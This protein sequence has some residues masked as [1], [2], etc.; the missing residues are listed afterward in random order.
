[1]ASFLSP[2][3]IESVKVFPKEDGIN[4]YELYPGTESRGIELLKKM[5]KFNPAERITAEEALKDS[6]FDDIRLPEQESS[7]DTAPV[8]LEFDS[9]VNA[10]LSIEEL[11]KLVV[12]EIEQISHENFDFANDFAEELCDDY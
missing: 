10:E 3:Q 7:A 1:M 9:E 5:L 2:K 8:N 4:L 6:Y 11:K 12:K